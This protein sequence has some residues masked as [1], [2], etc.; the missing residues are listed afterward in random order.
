MVSSKVKI[1]VILMFLGVFINFIPTIIYYVQVY[2]HIPLDK[3]GPGAYFVYKITTDFPLKFANGSEYDL[4]F[5]GTLN[6]TVLDNGTYRV[7]LKGTA[8]YFRPLGSSEIPVEGSF[9]LNS[10]D[11]FIRML[12]V[13]EKDMV[14]V[15]G[16]KTAPLQMQPN[17][18][19]FHTFGGL[20]PYT[21]YYFGGGGEVSYVLFGG[22][23]LVMSELLLFLP[24]PYDALSQAP[25]IF[26][27]NVL[28]NVDTIKHLTA[29]ATP[30]LNESILLVGPV[31]TNVKTVNN[32]I[33]EITRDSYMVFFPIN[34]VL[35]L[36]GA[37]ILVLELRGKL[38]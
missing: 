13:N 17:E 38:H 26:Y 36:I 16:N 1:A 5:N 25:L 30:L 19:T 23:E 14:A 27:Y 31:A 37:I 6:V 20:D 24:Q 2:P 22:G 21:A 11:P 29:N 10:S 3:V 7:T 4:L 32:V 34:I 9:V 28:Q 18:Y 35:I 33:G 15:I 12:F 8:D